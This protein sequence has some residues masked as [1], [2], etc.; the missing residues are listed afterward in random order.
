MED[1]SEADFELR[2]TVRQLRQSLCE[3]AGDGAGEFPPGE[4]HFVCGPG[5]QRLHAAAK[6]RIQQ[7]PELELQPACWL[8]LRSA[9]KCPLGDA[10]RDRFVPRLL[11]AGERGEWFEGQSSGPYRSDLL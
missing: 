7:R 6:P 2:L 8:R 4:R 9:G 5:S 3:A 1:E 11:H 10:W